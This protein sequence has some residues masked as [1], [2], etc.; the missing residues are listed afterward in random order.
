MFEQVYRNPIVKKDS[1]LD[2]I[3]NL[4]FSLYDFYMDAPNLLPQEQQDMLGEY[5]IE[6]VVKDHIA[7]MTD[8]YAINLYAHYFL[9]AGW[10]K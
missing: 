5:G 7:N 4:I 10:K 1:E 2:K 3:R 9:P 6:E 8:R